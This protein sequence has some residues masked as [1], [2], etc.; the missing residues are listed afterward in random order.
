[1][2]LKS[3]TDGDLLYASKLNENFKAINDKVEEDTGAIPISMN[4]GIGSGKIS[5]RKIGKFV[6]FGGSSAI[7]DA[8]LGD[9]V[10]IY[11]IPPEF[12]PAK[13]GF[14]FLQSPHTDEV[15]KLQYSLTEIRVIW[16]SGNQDFEFSFDDLSWETA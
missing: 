11:D 14:A 13:P 16:S 3:F 9:Q 4:H 10:K 15:V 5:L 6:R 8:N 1:M 7:G 2:N 12:A